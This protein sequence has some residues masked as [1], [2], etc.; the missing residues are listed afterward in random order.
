MRTLLRNPQLRIIVGVAVFTLLASGLTLRAASTNAPVS[1]KTEGMVVQPPYVEPP[2]PQSAFVLP[3]NET[4]GRDPFFPKSS[5]IHGVDLSNKKSDDPV[6]VWDLTLKGISGTP[7]QPLA[8]INNITF[9][10]G[11]EN[12]VMTKAGRISIR[13]LEINKDAGNAVVQAGGQRREL[14]LAPLK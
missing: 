7:E 13:C 1:A 6:P 8:I 10:V 12:S 2:I 5:R 14:R 3:K 4:E 9:A 11:E